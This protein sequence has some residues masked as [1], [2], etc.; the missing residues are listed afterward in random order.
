MSCHVQFRLDGLDHIDRHPT[1]EAAIEAACL[2]IEDGYDVFGIGTGPLEH[3]I[4]REQ[5]ARLY[6]LWLRPRNP[7]RLKPTPTIGNPVM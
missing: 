2:L 6:A 7:F 5:I 1:P 3:S 4:D